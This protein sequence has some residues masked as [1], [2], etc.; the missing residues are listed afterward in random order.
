MPQWIVFLVVAI[1]AWLVLS[2]GGGL[3]IGRL[4]RLIG[5]RRPGP[6]SRRRVA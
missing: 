4:L 1:G 3:L 6:G 2:V 5:G